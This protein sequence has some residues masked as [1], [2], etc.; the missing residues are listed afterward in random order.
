[1][2]KGDVVMKFDGQTAAFVQATLAA[3]NAMDA[4]AEKGRKMG[5]DVSKGGDKALASLEKVGKKSQQ[6]KTDFISA[7]EAMAGMAAAA[8]LAGKIVSDRMDEMAR[9]AGLTRDA[10]QGINFALGA[11]GQISQAPEIR[12]KLSKIGGDIM[13]PKDVEALFGQVSKAAGS[14]NTPEEKLR[15]TKAAVGARGAGIEDVGAFGNT[16][17]QLERQKGLAGLS[18]DQLSEVTAHVLKVKPA[19]LSDKDLRFLQR[20]PDQMEGLNML[21]AGGRSAEGSKALEAF[22]QSGDLEI[23]DDLLKKAKHHP[24][25]LTEEEKR[26]LRLNEI[27][28]EDRQGAMLRDPSLVEPS[29]RRAVANLAA[30]IGDSEI[31][32]VIAGSSFKQQANDI[33]S[34]EASNPE[35]RAAAKARALEAEAGR[36]DRIGGT[37]ALVVANLKKDFETKLAKSG[38]EHPILMNGVTRWLA[39]TYNDVALGTA[40]MFAKDPKKE[41]ER[42]EEHMD[43]LDEQN[44]LLTTRR[45]AVLSNDSEGQK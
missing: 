34:A 3:K 5:E 11:S 39:S 45:G 27:P 20:S 44:R 35:D 7:G 30:H 15:A 19:G 16:F 14:M 38:E 42:H 41:E 33:K 24:K 13:A 9:K 2:A 12:K 23:N 21:L 37:K 28:E 18:D 31:Q 10:I 40:S 43:K 36:V 17:A 8:A 4:A 26:K 22:E 6:V 25:K 1:M 32:G 29:Q